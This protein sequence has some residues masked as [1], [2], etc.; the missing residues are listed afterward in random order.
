[1]TAAV[2]GD[3]HADHLFPGLVGADPRRGW[4]LVGQTSCPPALGIVAGLKGTP[5]VCSR[6]VPAAL[7][8]IL[9]SPGIRTVAI[10]FL[11]PYYI[12]E[13][14]VAASHVGTW[15]PANYTLTAADRAGAGK[16]EA[17]EAGLVKTVQAL[18]AAGKS[19][20]LVADIPEMPFYPWQC[21]QRFAG[22]PPSVDCSL[23]LAAVQERQ[24]A[25]RAML[26]AVAAAVP[27]VRI[28]DSLPVLCPD[29]RCAMVRDGVPIY[30]DPHHLSLEGSTWIASGLVPLLGTRP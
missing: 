14:A 18:V 17:L 12:S 24:G 30:R 11:G 6:T 13:T 21:V 8:V 9:R 15:S 19:V 5:E 28:F 1:V 7:D 26:S 10:A 2:L 29:G 4:L 22:K 27:G 23:P 25:Y 16:R 20:V 3:S